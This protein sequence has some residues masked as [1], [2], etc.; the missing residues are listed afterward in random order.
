MM[1]PDQLADEVDYQIERCVKRIEGIGA[2]QYAQEEDQK[3]E[4]MDLD[5]LFEYANEELD[6]IINYAVMLRIRLDRLRQAAKAH[7]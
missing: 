6:D 3:F 7:T 4:T 1:T 2:D 5:D